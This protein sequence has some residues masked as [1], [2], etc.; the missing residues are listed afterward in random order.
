[1]QQRQRQRQQE[2]EATRPIEARLLHL[3]HNGGS[4]EDIMAAVA[5]LRTV[6][7][8]KAKRIRLRKSHHPHERAED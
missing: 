6:K 1:M 7:A 5:E 3:K 4:H 8:K 2:R